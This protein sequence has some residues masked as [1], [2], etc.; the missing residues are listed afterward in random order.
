MLST[1]FECVREKDIRL[2]KQCDHAKD[3]VH[4]DKGPATGGGHVSVTLPG[5]PTRAKSSYTQ[6]IYKVVNGF[7]MCHCLGSGK[8]HL[9][10]F[11]RKGKRGNL[12]R[13]R[14]KVKT[15]ETIERYTKFSCQAPPP[16]CVT[17]P[18]RR[19]VDKISRKTWGQK[20]LQKVPCALPA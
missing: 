11:H 8:R 18:R 20:G 10:T 13:I 12:K 7:I 16:L 5:L 2:I 15:L 1:F 14:K 6:Q 3:H 9:C 4:Q 19:G 17:G